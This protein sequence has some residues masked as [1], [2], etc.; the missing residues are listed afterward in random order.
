LDKTI[1]EIFES[2]RKALYFVERLPGLLEENDPRPSMSE[3][4]VRAYYIGQRRLTSGEHGDSKSDWLK[5]ETELIE[6]R[7][8]G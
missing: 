3:I 6:E 8:S 2:Y 7:G 4:E 1:E 5:A